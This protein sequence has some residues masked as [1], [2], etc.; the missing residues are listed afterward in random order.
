MTVTCPKCGGSG[1]ISHFSHVDN[2]VCFE[3][4]GSGVVDEKSSGPSSFDNSQI[5]DEIFSL[6]KRMPNGLCFAQVYVW[7]KSPSK[8][9]FGTGHWYAKVSVDGR[10][11][12]LGTDSRRVSLVEVRAAYR[13][14]IADGYVPIAHEDFAAVFEK[15]VKPVFSCYR[16][17]F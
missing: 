5:V 1:Y 15:E 8:K 11:S 16:E 6:I 9:D 10:D 13:M 14:L 2:G 3:C 12:E 17:E 7:H 4:M